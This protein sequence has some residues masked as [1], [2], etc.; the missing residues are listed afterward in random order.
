MGGTVIFTSIARISSIVLAMILA[1]N[2]SVEEG[3]QQWLAY[4]VLILQALVFIFYFFMVLVKI[5]E[6]LIRLFGGGTFDESNHP[7][8]GGIFAAIMDLDCLNGVRGGKAAARKKRKRDS[9]QLQRNVSVAGSLTTQMMLD[10][11]SQGVERQL[12]GYTRASMHAQRGYYQVSNPSVDHLGGR[13]SMSDQ[14]SITSMSEENRI[15]DMWRPMVTPT[16]GYSDM[17]PLASPS[18]KS[19]VNSPRRHSTG[20]P[21]TAPLSASAT[22]RARP[23]SRSTAE[24]TRHPPSSKNWHRLHPRAT[25]D[26]LH[27]DVPPLTA[28]RSAQRPDYSDIP[29]CSWHASRQQRCSPASINHFQASLSEQHCDRGGWSGRGFKR[30]S[31]WFGRWEAMTG[32]EHAEAMTTMTRT[33]SLD[34]AALAVATGTSA[35]GCRPR[36]IASCSSRLQGSVHA[37]GQAGRADA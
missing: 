20:W 17:Q 16:H 11:H 26:S 13:R 25:S 37:Q 34:R 27:V 8:D 22:R 35:R 10:R 19:P 29:A 33:T 24:R 9:R 4:V 12:G 30:R 1:P 6:G 18:E 28:I 32:L 5:L 7:I 15:M 2:V 31:A 3:S 36:D 21:Q 23:T 14:G